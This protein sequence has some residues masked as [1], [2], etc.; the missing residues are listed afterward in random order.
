MSCSLV[1]LQVGVSLRQHA[2]DLFGHD[3][4]KALDLLHLQPT[5]LC[6]LQWQHSTRVLGHLQA[7]GRSN[8]L[9]ALGSLMWNVVVTSSTSIHTSGGIYTTDNQPT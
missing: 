8:V 1:Y 2:L 4:E 5:Q 9:G 6:I 3:T 7:K